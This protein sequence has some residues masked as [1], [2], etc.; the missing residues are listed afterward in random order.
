MEHANGLLKEQFQSLREL[1]VHISNCKWY[2][3]AILWIRCCIILHNLILKLEESDDKP[4]QDTLCDIGRFGGDEGDR[5]HHREET[6][7]DGTED[8]SHDDVEKESDYPSSG[9]VFR[10]RL[11]SHILC[12]HPFST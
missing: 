5:A 3:W 1:R 7:E 8:S 2:L 9:S 10:R 6:E 12:V 4:W 11:L